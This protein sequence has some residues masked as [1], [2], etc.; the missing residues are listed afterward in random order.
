M[1]VEELDDDLKFGMGGWSFFCLSPC[2]KRL[3]LDMGGPIAPCNP[4]MLQ[5]KL[6]QHPVLCV[7]LGCTGRLRHSHQLAQLGSLYLYFFN[8]YSLRTKKEMALARRARLF[9]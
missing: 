4:L 7:I 1:L 9:V 6:Q 5:P 3:P 8:R 2:R